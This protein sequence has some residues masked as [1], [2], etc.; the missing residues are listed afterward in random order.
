MTSRILIVDDA[1]F[2]RN[3]LRDV[4]TKDSR[5]EV[6]GEA[7]N[8]NEAIEKYQQLRPDLVTMDIVMPGMDG[9]EAVRKLVRQDPGAR[10]VMVSALGQEALVM[11]S[12]VAGARDFVVK[13]FEPEKVIKTVEG[14][15][16]R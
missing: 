16:K 10:V 11:E 9:I 13:P 7:S 6:V 3:L 2:M 15:L 1:A 8:G 5:F 4:F 14:A 12:L